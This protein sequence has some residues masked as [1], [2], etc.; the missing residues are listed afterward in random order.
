MSSAANPNALIHYGD[1][2]D[3]TRSHP[4]LKFLEKF[5]YYWDGREWTDNP[6]T[7][8][9]WLT[10]DFVLRQANGNV[11]IGVDAA[12]AAAH[13]NYRPLTAHLHEPTYIVIHDS[14]GGWEMIGQATLYA[15]LMGEP[16]KGEV[17]V[18]DGKGKEWDMGVPSAFYVTFAKDDGAKNG[19]GVLIKKE[20]LMS[21]SGVAM[22]ILLKRG[23]VSAKD[24]GL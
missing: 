21:D 17:K 2:D 22:G 4:A 16:V 7:S 9:Q 12:I 11:V 18:K 20:E 1:W 24:L 10:S 19:M 14:T 6:E 5:V 23:V 3:H 13:T 15:N 8:A